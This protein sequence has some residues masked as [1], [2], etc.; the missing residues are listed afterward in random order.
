MPPSHGKTSAVASRAAT[1]E[2]RE[3]KM[4]IRRLARRMSA[5]RHV[6]TSLLAAI[7]FVALWGFV[8]GEGSA[9]AEVRNPDGVAVIVG[10]MDYS[11]VGDVAYAHRD[12]EAFHR[13]VIDVLGFD[14]RN[15]RLVA[16]ADF[17]Q[18]RSLF[19]TEGNPGILGRFVE[20]R[21]E[22]SGGGTV[23]DVVV[24]YSGHG[25]PSLN[26][27]EAGSY[28]LGVNANPNNPSHNGYSVEELYRVLGA[29]PARSVSV[30]L[31]ACFSGV[32]GDGMPLLRASPAAATRLPENVSENTVVFAAAEGQQIA[33]WD[34][35]AGHGLFTHHLLDALYGGGD[36][37]GDGRVTAGEVH[38]Y[39]AEHVWYAALDVHGREQDAVLIDGTGT[40]ARVLAAAMDGAF[41]ERPDLGVPDAVA[42]DDG[43]DAP[44][45]AVDHAAVELSL[46]LKRSEMELVQLGL[47]S[48]GFSPGEIDGL[49]GKN[50]R[51]ALGA[52]QV[53]RGHAATGF[54]TADHAKAL[55]AAGK[56]AQREQTERERA[57]REREDRER[58]EREQAAR[59]RAEREERERAEAERLAKEEA[60]RKARPEE[61]SP[62][63]KKLSGLL[64]RPFSPT[65]V[66]E[67]GWTDLHYAAILN[68]P[69]VARALLDAGADPEARLLNDHNPFTG[70]LSQA[71]RTMGR[72][73]DGW[74]RGGWSP[75]YLAAMWNSSNVVRELIT[76]GA[77]VNAPVG[78]WTP[79]HTAAWNNYG[80]AIEELIAGLADVNA[81]T[82]DTN[83][84]LHL[85]A[86]QGAL[87]AAD[88]LIVGHADI[89]AR[90]EKSYYKGTWTEDGWTPLHM[91]ARFD[92]SDIAALLISNGADIDEPDKNGDTPLHVTTCYKKSCESYDTARALIERG[93]DVNAMPLWDA[94]VD[95]WVRN[96]APLHLAAWDGSFAIA[97]LLLRNGADPN[98]RTEDG[99]TP[100]DCLN[101]EDKQ[102]K[103]KLGSL[104]QRY[105]GRKGSGDC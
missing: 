98:L 73:L 21:R 78:S 105:G 74:K 70:K 62:T 82:S 79:L 51:E 17:G 36:E 10:N 46:G 91:A 40:G 60:E 67:N 32:G 87:N 103:E 53:A 63:A 44:P 100:L 34:D 93:A 33:F 4:G 13:Y 50:T 48:A 5:F 11:D 81:R 30:F 69:E 80:N 88:E 86:M 66:D 9:F 54:L 42:G 96:W 92:R 19:G 97:K 61:S 99:G 101:A 58:A 29:L 95:G 8:C 35:E 57:E 77:D 20:K 18:M 41:P 104:L 85:A 52:W 89:G 76:G 31:D 75:L 65:A 90:S 49:P 1:Q 24:F 84:P 6:V 14:P 3:R 83:T 72:P 56:A 68:M 64:K 38:R 27:G 59:E 71:L 43:S 39:L 28:M 47:A 22:L 2:L 12:A 102:T 16:D 26:P 25:L 94:D 7:L 45:A 55:I 15:V 23:S 37:D